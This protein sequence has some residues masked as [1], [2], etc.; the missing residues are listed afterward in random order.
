[1]ERTNARNLGLRQQFVRRVLR[2]RRILKVKMTVDN[3]LLRLTDVQNLLDSDYPRSI[4]PMGISSQ[5]RIPI[6]IVQAILTRLIITKRAVLNIGLYQSGTALVMQQLVNIQPQSTTA[7]N[8]STKIGVDPTV[9]QQML[10]R[11]VLLGMAQKVVLQPSGAIQ[12]AAE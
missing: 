1:M 3:N 11:L 5:L 10:D 12:Y 8:I 2:R 9:V 6:P 4:S 7:S